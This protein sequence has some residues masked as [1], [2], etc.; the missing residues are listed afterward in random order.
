MNSK[1]I[2][3]ETPRIIWPVFWP[4]EW[5]C[6]LKSPRDNKKTWKK[7]AQDS[8]TNLMNRTQDKAITLYHHRRLWAPA[9]GP[10]T[11]AATFLRK[12]V[13][14]KKLQRGGSGRISCDTFVN[15]QCRSLP[16][17]NGKNG[18]H[19]SRHFLSDLSGAPRDDHTHGKHM[20]RRRLSS[21][22]AYRAVASPTSNLSNII[23]TLL[24]NNQRLYNNQNISKP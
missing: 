24:Y 20:R 3:C 23:I 15:H 4:I 17:C 6:L 14:K 12:H 2:T 7:M 16:L 13:P 5:G 10:V 19:T 8:W 1:E 9:A 22:S 21:C 18:K 11:T